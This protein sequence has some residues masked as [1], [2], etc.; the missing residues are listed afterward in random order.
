[1][2]GDVLTAISSVGFPIVACCYLA[3]FQN[4]TMEKFRDTIQQ[5]TTILEKLYT[6]LDD[7]DEGE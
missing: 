5:N 3:W 7:D 6:K 2:S 4:T 1:M